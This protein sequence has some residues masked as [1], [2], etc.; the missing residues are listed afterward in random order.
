MSGE[1]S[2]EWD[3]KCSPFKVTIQ[4]RNSRSNYMLKFPEFEPIVL[5]AHTFLCL[6]VSF[7]STCT[8]DAIQKI[9]LKGEL[10]PLFVFL[11]PFPL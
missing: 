11:S 8:L 7:L 3:E 4:I 1:E 10:Y 5:D 6:Q 2:W 9:F